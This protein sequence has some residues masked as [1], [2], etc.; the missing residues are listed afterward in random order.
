MYAI[1]S[2]YV[3]VAPTCMI[4]ARPVTEVDGDFDT[5][6]AFARCYLRN[7][8]LG[9]LLDLCAVSVPCA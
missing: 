9:N 6:M 2:Y 5:Y 1:R 7:C 8:F 4:P 3:L